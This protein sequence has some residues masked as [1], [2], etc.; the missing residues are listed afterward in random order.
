M[1]SDRSLLIKIGLFI[2]ASAM[3]GG[4]LKE[5][6][7]MKHGPVDHT[8][9]AAQLYNSFL[10]ALDYFTEPLGIVAV[11]LFVILLLQAR[12]K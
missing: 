5:R 8:D 12:G 10:G 6:M 2:F 7:R 3:V 4:Y 9:A 1:N 11:I